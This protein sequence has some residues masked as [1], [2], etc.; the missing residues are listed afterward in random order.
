MEELSFK[1]Q[2]EAYAKAHILIMGHGAAFANILFMAP[3]SRH[4]ISCTVTGIQW[5]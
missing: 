4:C 5:T 1:Q 3:V 2:L